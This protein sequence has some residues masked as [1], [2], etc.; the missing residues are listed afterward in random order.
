M[1]GVESSFISLPLLQQNLIFEIKVWYFSHFLC[2]N[3]FFFSRFAGNS[4]LTLSR[5]KKHI[6]GLIQRTKNWFT[7]PPLQTFSHKKH[8]PWH[9]LTSADHPNNLLYTTKCLHITVDCVTRDDKS[10][11]NHY[12]LELSLLISSV[13]WIVP[14][15]THDKLH[16]G[17]LL[18][19]L[20][21]TW[22]H[23]KS[24]CSSGLHGPAWNRWTSNPF[25]HIHPLVSANLIKAMPAIKN[26]KVLW[27]KRL[28]TKYKL[29]YLP[30]SWGDST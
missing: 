18:C 13:F 15:G 24:S 12:H 9:V 14:H 8:N 19:L 7:F 6:L 3:K 28:E 22:K 29:A 5:L 4:G 27:S 25:Q 11:S 23:S 20:S 16:I 17:I 26:M 1:G 10:P 30:S 21:D 2:Y